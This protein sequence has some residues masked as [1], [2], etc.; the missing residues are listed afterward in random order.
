MV[1]FEGF[2]PICNGEFTPNLDVSAE[3]CSFSGVAE[4]DHAD[5][6]DA[7]ARAMH[8]G[9]GLAMAE[10]A[11]VGVAS[12][13]HAVAVGGFAVHTGWRNDRGAQ[14]IAAHSGTLYAFA[15]NPGELHA[16]GGHAVAVGALAEHAVAADALAVG[17]G[18]V[19]ASCAD[20][21][22]AAVG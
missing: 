4:T 6:V 2:V 1:D 15:Y 5:T 12:T 17:A 18:A 13:A 8:A 22:G 21:T 7:V 19:P 20:H 11:D 14:A 16:M 10:H 9:G 3:I